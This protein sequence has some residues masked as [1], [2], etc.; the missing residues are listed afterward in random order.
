MTPDELLKLNRIELQ[1]VRP[2]RY[3]TTCPECSAKRR[4]VH[5]KSE[6]LGVT[7]ED[8]G[9]VRWG[10]NH[11]GW[12]GPQKGS[13]F[14]GGRFG[15]GRFG[16]G[17]SGGGGNRAPLAAYLYRDRDGNVRFRKLRNL[18]GRE[19]RFWLEHWD[20]A[21]G[22]LKGA[23]GADTAILYRI[24]EIASAIANGHVIAVVEGEKDADNLWKLDIP[25]TCNAHGASEPSKKPK[26]T[27]KHSEQLRG[28]DIVVLNDNDAAGF[29]H[30]KA[31]CTQ[32]IGIAK[33][34]RRLD[35]KNDWPGMANGQDVSDWLAVGGDHTPERLRKLIASAPDYVPQPEPRPEPAPEPAP[36]AAELERLARL[37]ALDYGRARKEAAKRLGTTVAFLDIAIKTKRA[38]LGIGGNGGIQGRAVEYEEPE[39]WPE[40]VDGA[41]LLDELAASAKRFTVLPPDAPEISALWVIHTYLL[42]ATDITPRLQISSPTKGC[43]KTT[44]LDWL[45]EVVHRPDLA[46]NIS[47]SALYRTVEKWRPTLLLDEA[48]SF[49]FENEAMRNVLNSGHHVKGAAKISVKVGDDYEPRIFSTFA[50]V[51]FG[52]IGE[53]KGVLATVNDR[54]IRIVLQRRKP[55]EKIESLSGP[56]RCDEFKPLRRRLVRWAQDHRAALAEAE[57]SVPAA[58]YNRVADN[59]WALIA[60]ADAAG[61]GWGEKARATA[62]RAA[63][64]EEQTTIEMLIATG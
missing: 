22:W 23:G 1:D 10:C 31:V 33:S 39:P 8:D 9:S 34:V 47:A 24:D 40:P 58:L 54:S 7:I 4:P 42:D 53:L 16:G 43:G 12:T 35:L 15:G 26:W 14:G 46:S 3:Y 37:S 55:K 11:C 41:K 62:L 60:I 20:E 57:P 36:D 29:A 17:G 28:A 32:S 38:E 50:P 59:W 63:P 52:L 48:D 6:C 49:L 5:Q 2:G 61:D 44:F 27:A 56:R 19:P 13:R 64:S 21:T 18:P 51:A 30:A 25:A 45:S